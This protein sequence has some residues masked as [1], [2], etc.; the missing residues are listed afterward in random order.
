MKI[1][2]VTTFPPSTGGLSEY[3]FHIAQQLQRNPFL[4]LTVLADELPAGHVEPEE[5]KVIRLWSFDDVGSAYRILRQLRRLKPD[6]VW[7]NLLFSTFGRN[8]WIAFTGLMTPLLARLSGRYTHVTL[9]HLMDTV[10]LKDAGVRHE[11]LYRFAGA[12]ATRMLLL[13][14]S[15]SVL[16][17]GYREILNDKY[18]RDN[19]HLRAHGILARRPEFPDFS[20]RGAPIHRILA[21][22]KWG[23]YKRLE[24]MIEAFNLIAAKLPEAKLVIAGGDHPQAAGYTE[25]V[26]LQCAG[27]PRI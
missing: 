8:P 20:R 22:G 9:H 2:L 23:T 17:P 6:V 3:G 14:N 13:A 5:F 18:G 26:R 1:C 24:L 21:F 4:N 15:V 7:F 11:G 25:S 12:F 16:M 19:V 27:N 10:E